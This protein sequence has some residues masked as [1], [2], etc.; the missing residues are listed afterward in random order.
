[1]TLLLKLDVESDEDGVVVAS[2]PNGTNPPAVMVV[3]TVLL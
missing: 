3:K 2:L 1:M